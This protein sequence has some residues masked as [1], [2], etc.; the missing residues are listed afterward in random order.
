MT[1]KKIREGILHLKRERIGSYA[2]KRHAARGAEQL[3]VWAGTFSS[4]PLNVSANCIHGW[5]NLFLN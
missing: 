3:K 4:G 2:Y 1:S 5:V